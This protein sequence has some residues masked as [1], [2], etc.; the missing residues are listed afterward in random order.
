MPKRKLYVEEE[1]E[2]EEAAEV[3]EV[4]EIYAYSASNFSTFNAKY[5]E[6]YTLFSDVMKSKK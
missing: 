1:E 4:E 5:K 3:E 6:M 2:E